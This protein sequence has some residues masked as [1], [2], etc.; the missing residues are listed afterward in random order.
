MSGKIEY[1]DRH[2]DYYTI[3]KIHI[4]KIAFYGEW[5]KCAGSDYQ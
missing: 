1:K 2:E 4:T 5:K 3:L